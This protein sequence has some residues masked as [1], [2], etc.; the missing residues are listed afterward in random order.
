MSDT[1]Y[2]FETDW[3]AG[4]LPGETRQ[5]DPE[6]VGVAGSA[7]VSMGTG[8]GQHG[9][10]PLVTGAG[11]MG[12]IGGAV[13]DMWDTLHKPFASPYSAIDIGLIVGVIMVAIILWSLILYHIRIAAESI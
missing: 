3:Q 6:S 7:G 13:S 5:A 8:T 11:S 1:L 10:V 12:G 9:V 4:S 2:D